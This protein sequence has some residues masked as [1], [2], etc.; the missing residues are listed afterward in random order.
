MNSDDDEILSQINVPARNKRTQRVANAKAEEKENSDSRRIRTNARKEFNRQ[1]SN[2]SSNFV[3]SVA[4]S[5]E[6]CTPKNF[7]KRNGNSSRLTADVSQ[8]AE[9]EFDTSP[10]RKSTRSSRSTADVSQIAETEFESPPAKTTAKRSA[11]LTADVSQIAET[12]FDLPPIRKKQESS[13]D[14]SKIA[15][16]EF[17]TAP[18]RKKSTRSTRLTA[19]VSHVSETQF[20]TAPVSKKSPGRTQTSD[21]RYERRFLLYFNC[22]LVKFQ[23]QNLRYRFQPHLGEE[24]RKQEASLLRRVRSR[25]E[26]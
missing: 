14:V 3:E 1:V 9:T 23:K 24:L 7:A 19:D 26:L 15:E 11:R 13:A 5:E 21:I 2:T 18:A 12:E 8:V 4:D 25:T 16:T 10:V 22:F 6:F 20:D 17:D